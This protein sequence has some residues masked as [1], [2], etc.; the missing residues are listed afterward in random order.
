MPVSFTNATDALPQF[1]TPAPFININ[2]DFDKQ[3]D[4]EILGA[5]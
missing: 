3:G 2:K 5:R 1:L 4:G